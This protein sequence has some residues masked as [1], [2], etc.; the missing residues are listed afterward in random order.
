MLIILDGKG[1]WQ[2]W[3]RRSPLSAG[4]RGPLRQVGARLAAHGG[5]SS[6]LLLLHPSFLAAMG[7]FTLFRV[8][9]LSGRDEVSWF[10]GPEW[11]T[12]LSWITRYCLWGWCL[13]LSM[14]TLPSFLEPDSLRVGCVYQMA[15]EAD[16]TELW[17]EEAWAHWLAVCLSCMLAYRL[18]NLDLSNVAT[19][20]GASP[21]W[22]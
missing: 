5:G 20:A 13:L 15:E 18:A 21:F 17:I 11:A 8:F 22:M 10:Y 3:G 14:L 9:C 12:A 2:G 1:F 16:N 19:M 4:I 7:L 6:S